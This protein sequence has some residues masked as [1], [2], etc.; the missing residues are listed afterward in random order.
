MEIVITE[1][2][3][4]WF[5]ED[6][7]YKSGDK[8]RFFV[9]I[10]GSSPVQEGYSLAFAKDD[11]LD[12]AVSVESEGILF[13]VEETDLWFFDGH[14]LHVNYDEQEDELEYNYIKP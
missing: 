14:D 10:Y 5:K 1:Q 7:G 3:L 9:K 8:V 11:P 4:K 6:I 2:A 12:I 13:F